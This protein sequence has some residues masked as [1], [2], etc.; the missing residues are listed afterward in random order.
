MKKAV[1]GRKHLLW[2]LTFRYLPEPAFGYR[3][4]A[5]F[6]D[7]WLCVLLTIFQL[8]DQLCTNRYAKDIL[9]YP[10]S[11]RTIVSMIAGQMMTIQLGICSP[12]LGNFETGLLCQSGKRCA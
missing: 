1:C 10:V 7:L 8:P 5:S 4:L 2:Y 11:P 3:T 9:C 12:P 6:L